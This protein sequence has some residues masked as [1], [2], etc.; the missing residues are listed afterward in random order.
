[1]LVPTCLIWTTG[2]PNVGWG[3]GGSLGEALWLVEAICEVDFSFWPESTLSS[4]A[5]MWKSDLWL[6][7]RF[8]Q[9]VRTNGDPLKLNAFKTL[10][11]MYGTLIFYKVS[12]SSLTRKDLSGKYAQYHAEWPQIPI[13]SLARKWSCK[14]ERSVRYIVP[15]R[16]F[17]VYSLIF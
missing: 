7:T 3:N 2:W 12:F 5:E 10:F 9:C 1:M 11:E 8:T 16:T 17:R 13:E 4:P 6:E 14:P 15:R